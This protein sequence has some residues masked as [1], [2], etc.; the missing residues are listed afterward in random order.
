MK[1]LKVRSLNIDDEEIFE[2][3]IFEHIASEVEYLTD[4]SIKNNKKYINYPNFKEWY[5]NKKG[6]TYLVL[7][8]KTVVGAFELHECAD[9]CAV[10]TLDVRPTERDKGYGKIILNFIR[11]LC[12]LKDIDNVTITSSISYLPLEKESKIDNVIN[13]KYDISKNKVLI[14]KY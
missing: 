7:T 13:Y 8:N 11:N 6:E 4:S 5:K 2:E 1:N 3:F 14:K 12:S 9:K 10:I